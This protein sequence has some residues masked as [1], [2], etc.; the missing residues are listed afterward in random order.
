MGIAVDAANLAT[1]RF[2]VDVGRIRRV[3]EHPEAIAAIHVFPSGIGHTARIR[4]VSYPG[5]VV[6]ETAVDVIRIGVVHAYVI[7]LRD[8][9]IELMLPA[10][11]AVFTSPKACVIG[12]IH[13]IGIGGI[14]P[15]IVKVTMGVA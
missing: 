6:L 7:E 1:L 2:G 8:R 9:Q 13:D 11:A 4:R 15:H 12:C 10:C 14:D 3:F 5:A